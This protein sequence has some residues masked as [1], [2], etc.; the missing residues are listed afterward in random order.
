VSANAG[1]PRLP[2]EVVEARMDRYWRP[3]TA[4]HVAVFAATRAGKT[5]LITHHLLPLCAGDRVLIID[6]KGDDGAWDGYGKPVSGLTPAF[7]RDA[8]GGG[9]IGMWFRLI[10]NL[11]DIAAA[12]RTVKRAL[13]QVEA[14]GH[15]IVIIDESRT[16]CDPKYLNCMSEVESILMRGG[17]RNL[18]LVIAAQSIGY[19]PVSVKDQASFIL[20]GHT[21]D[22]ERQ[23]RLLDVLGMPRSA[24]PALQ[25]IQQRSWLYVDRQTHPSFA[26]L[27]GGT[28]P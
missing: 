8:E 6:V 4:P 14:E 22:A 5:H 21:I 27:T 13:E 10:V 16:V 25:G 18:S 20:V 17:S 11:K 28:D 9:P 23:K 26:A 15:C 7:G 19:A 24:L 1:I 2:W 3:D 12:R